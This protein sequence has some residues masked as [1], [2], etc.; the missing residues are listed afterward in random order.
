VNVY[1]CMYSCVFRVLQVYH[2]SGSASNP[3]VR[4]ELITEDQVRVHKGPDMRDDSEIQTSSYSADPMVIQTQNR[5]I[6][7]VCLLLYFLLICC[8]QLVFIFVS[9]FIGVF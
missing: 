5:I 9:Y 7:C 8:C 3:F 2:R 6:S 1:I 4:S